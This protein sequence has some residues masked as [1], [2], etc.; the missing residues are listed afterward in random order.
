MLPLKE[1]RILDINSEAAGVDVYTLMG[2]AGCRLADVLKSRYS[3]K[4]F[5]F[6]CGTGN[7]GGD[8]FAATRS[9]ADEDVTVCLIRPASFIRSDAAKRYFSEL[10]CPVICIGDVSFDRYDVLVDCALGTG[11]TGDVRGPYLDYIALAHSFGGPIVSADVPS[12]FGSEDRIRPDITVTFHDIKEGMD[13]NNSGEIVIE[14]IGIP[15]AASDNV[16]PGDMLRY[17]KPEPDSHKGSNGRVLLISGGPYYG[18]PVMSGLAALRIGA[19]I[20]RIAV[21]EHAAPVVSGFS[22]VF[23]IEPL[24]GMFLGKDHVPHL[25]EMSKNHDA[26]LIGPGIG[27]DPDTVDAVKRFVSDCKVPLVIDADAISAIGDDYIAKVPTVITPHKKEFI[28]LGGKD[29]SVEKDVLSL[30][31]STKSVILLK[32][33]TDIISDGKRTKKNTSGTPAMTGAGTG[34]VLAGIVAGLISKGMSPFDAASLGAYISG[35]AGEYGFSEKSYGLIATDVIDNIPTVLNNS[36]K[37]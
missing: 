37:E 28:V 20:V 8:G 32:G 29:P 5:L 26:V 6:V 11:Q 18:A 12:G 27:I 9:M 30:A 22:P 14:D 24:N 21:P 4:R 35:K 1:F 25:I 15:E 2:N 19:D 13:P 36:F 16:G 23:I 17:P 33:R 3:G 31:S 34:D 10:S 7:N